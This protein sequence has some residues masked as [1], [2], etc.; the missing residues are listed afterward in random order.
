MERKGAF[1]VN[2]LQAQEFLATGL[3]ADN[4]EPRYNFEMLSMK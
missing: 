3:Q 1:S 2:G 4:D